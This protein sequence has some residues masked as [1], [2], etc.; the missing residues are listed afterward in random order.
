LS[1][2]EAAEEGGDTEFAT[3]YAAYGALGD[4]EKAKLD[5]LRVVHR[6]ARAIMRAYPDASEKQRAAWNK[7]P[8]REHPLVWRHRDGRCSLVIGSTADHI[9][10]MDADES[11]ALLD[12]LLDWSTQPQFVL[13]HQWRRGDLVMWDNTGML[14]R[15]MPFAETSRRL[16][17]RTTLVG[18][19]ATG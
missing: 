14:H 4:D 15:A 5:G 18:T 8:P 17:H 16:L 11:E 9:I 7:Q 19:E 2:R 12:H 10:G 13:R 6:F 3:T 1:A